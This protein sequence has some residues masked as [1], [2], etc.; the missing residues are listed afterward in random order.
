MEIQLEVYSTI[1]VLQYEMYGEKPT[2]EF[3]SYCSSA[4]P[5]ETHLKNDITGHTSLLNNHDS[6]VDR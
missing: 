3:I 4:R 2:I 6:G 1:E 5:N